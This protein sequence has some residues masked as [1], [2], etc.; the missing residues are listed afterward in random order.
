M[1]TGRLLTANN[2]NSAVTRVYDAAGR[3]THDQQAVT[4]L[5]TKDVTYPLYDD[6]GRV[7]QISLT[8]AYDYT[9]D[10]D[11]MGRLETISPANSVR[12]QLF[13]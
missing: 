5:G 1:P 12:F 6:D 2:P 10:Y 8:G 9:F 13:L 7:K 3:L 11:T 4:G